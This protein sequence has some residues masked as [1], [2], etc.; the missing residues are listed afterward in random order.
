ML[1]ITYSVM[2]KGLESEGWN[3]TKLKVEVKASMTTK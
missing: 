3:F 1:G 2:K